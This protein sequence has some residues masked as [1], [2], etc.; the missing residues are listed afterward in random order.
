MKNK[1]FGY[2]F[3]EG[4]RGIF[5]HGFMSFATICVTIACLI[6]VGSFYLIML[7]VNHIVSDL[8]K[9][10]QVIA[11]VDETYTEAEAKSV[12][13]QINK[14]GN[15]SNAQFVTKEEALEKFIAS[16]DNPENFSG[17]QADFFRHRY[18]ITLETSE[19]MEQTTNELK[20]IPGVAKVMAKMEIAE[21]FAT[22][23]G[24]LSIVSSAIIIVLLVVSL[25]IISN[26]VKLAIYDRKD[27]IGIMKMVGATN[28]FIRIPFVIEGFFIGLISAVIAFF[29]QWG[30]YDFLCGKIASLDTA[31]QLFAVVPFTTVLIRMIGTC[32][33][34][35]LLVGVFGSL[36]SI[37][38]F[39]DV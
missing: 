18:V 26:T 24:I 31:T 34:A 32:I 16:Q 35:G 36:L 3:K 1:N 8:D 13:T 28:G 17:L 6:I 14:L 9:Q 37:R 4:I 20:A 11:Y 10:N 2:L 15:I 19:G 21:G 29:A 39:L 38:K 27:E 12:G 23:R 5:L 22:V 30:I 33:A 7:N 25:F